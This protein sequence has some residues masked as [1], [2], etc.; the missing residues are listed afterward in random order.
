MVRRDFLKNSALVAATA[1]LYSPLSAASSDDSTEK[2]IIAIVSESAHETGYI[3][4]LEKGDKADEVIILG[5]DRLSTM[6]TLA[7]AIENNKGSLFCGLLAPSDHALLNQVAMSKGIAFVSETA[8]TPSNTGISHTENTF[9]M[10]S[11]KKA[12]DQFASL[13]TDKYGAA[14]SS[15]HTIGAHNTVA[16]AKQTDFV[17]EHTAKNAFVSFVLK[18]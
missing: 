2:K 14:L 5:S 7:S 10:L 3:S 17:S 8:H 18:A 4:A 15:Y 16:T 13:N 9:A 1:A 12:F 11:V 6:H